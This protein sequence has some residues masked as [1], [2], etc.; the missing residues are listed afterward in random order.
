MFMGVGRVECG[1]GFWWVWFWKR[2]H[3]IASS[4]LNFA[5]YTRLAMTSGL[6]AS[7]F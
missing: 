2:C 4:G 5:V 3:Y 1:F 7:A 6:P